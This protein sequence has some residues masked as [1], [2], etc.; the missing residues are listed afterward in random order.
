MYYYPR[1]DYLTS[2]DTGLFGVETCVFTI[3]G[4]RQDSSNMFIAAGEKR[5]NIHRIVLSDFNTWKNSGY[6]LI[7]GYEKFVGNYRVLFDKYMIE[8]N[9][10]TLVV[11]DNILK[12]STPQLKM[13]N[14]L[15]VEGGPVCNDCGQEYPYADKM[16]PNGILVC[17]GCKIMKGVFV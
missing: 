17:K 2:K 16:Q 7:D 1:G 10:A 5:I 12:I 11:G 15:G 9:R 13:V 4:E 3:I 6:K 8:T 14:K